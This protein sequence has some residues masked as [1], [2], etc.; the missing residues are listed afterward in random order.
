MTADAYRG[1][2]YG[3]IFGL[4]H[5]SNGLG[6]ALGPWLGGALY[7]ALGSYQLAFGV[8]IGSVGLA[9]ASLWLAG[10]RRTTAGR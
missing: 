1:P 6:A 2:Q 5:L 10:D 4:V 7:D 3:T 8:A 9:C